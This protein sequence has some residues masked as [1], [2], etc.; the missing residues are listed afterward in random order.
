MKM[1]S[2]FHF[3][4]FIAL[5]GF[6][7][8]CSTLSITKGR[9]L[10]TPMDFKYSDFDS[11][12][13]ISEYQIDVDDEIDLQMFANEGY[14]IVSLSGGNGLAN[15]QFQGG[16]KFKVRG[17]STIR[18]PIIGKVKVVGLTLEGLEQKFEKLLSKQFQSPF[19][20]AGIGNRRVYLFSGLSSARVHQLQNQNTTLFEV[21]ANSGGIPPNSNASKIKIIR[22]DLKDPDIYRVDLST[23]E[24]MKEANL[25]LLAGDIIYIEPFIN[26]GTVF[27]NDVSNL[28]SVL[29]TSLLVYTLFQGD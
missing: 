1:K 7:S 5:A 19:V 2:K 10:K 27:T 17:D 23:V 26:Y 8:S 6:L 25:T 20:I 15:V 11:A 21:L 24:G 14:N 9:I 4:L 16:R 13:L 3:F 12:A 29:T 28:L 18:V 22:G